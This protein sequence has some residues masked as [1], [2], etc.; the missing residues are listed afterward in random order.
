MNIQTSLPL[1]ERI[2]RFLP[3]RTSPTPKRVHIFRS[4]AWGTDK[5]GRISWIDPW[6]QNILHDEGE[7]LILSAVL[8]TTYSGYGATPANM[9]LG[10]DNRATLAEADTLASLSGE[11]SAGGYARKALST[12]GTGAAGQPFVLSQPGAYYIATSSNQVWTASGA[13][14]GTVKNR[15]LTTHL[16][17]TTSASGQRLVASLALSA[18]RT[19]NDGDS[20]TA[21]IIV[22]MSE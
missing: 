22:G 17:A 3:G 9:Y 19:I 8:A 5:F 2:I 18:T 7:Q 13:A 15:F 12:A 21:N 1:P 6:V 20:L 16:T 10:L 4:M 11:P 14:Y